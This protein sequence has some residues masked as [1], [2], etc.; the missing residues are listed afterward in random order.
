MYECQSNYKLDNRGV[1]VVCV[2]VVSVQEID[3]LRF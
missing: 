3:I 1:K 2:V